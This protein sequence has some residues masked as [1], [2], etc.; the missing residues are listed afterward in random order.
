MVILSCRDD[1]AGAL[2]HIQHVVF[3]KILQHHLGVIPT[4]LLGFLY[5]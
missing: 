3:P 4:Q 5:E 1:S 2:T